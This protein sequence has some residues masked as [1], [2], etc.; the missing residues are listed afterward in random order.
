MLEISDLDSLLHTGKTSDL[1]GLQ[2]C[3]IFMYTGA[4]RFNKKAALAYSKAESGWRESQTENPEREK[5]GVGDIP[6]ATRQTRH[7]RGQVK[8]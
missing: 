3:G 6:A 2:W 7:T 1:E 5:G 8:T 4:L